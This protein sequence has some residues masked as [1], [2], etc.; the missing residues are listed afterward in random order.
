MPVKNGN[1]SKGPFYRWGDS[2]KKYYY[3][4][5]NEKSKK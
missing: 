5:N 4:T 3:A 2:G 1:D